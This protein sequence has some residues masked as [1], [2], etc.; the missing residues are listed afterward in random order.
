MLYY[1]AIYDFY[2]LFISVLEFIWNALNYYYI[3]QI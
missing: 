3:Y 1:S 2:L